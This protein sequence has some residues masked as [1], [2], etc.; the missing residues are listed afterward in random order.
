[1]H[2]YLPFLSNVLLLAGAGIQFVLAARES[3]KRE[4]DD[5]ADVRDRRSVR[6]IVSRER[7]YR[8]GWVVLMLGTGVGAWSTWPW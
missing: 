3:A 6:R 2:I 8:D 1:M 7:W 4:N 5:R